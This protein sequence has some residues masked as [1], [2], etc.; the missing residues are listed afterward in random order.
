MRLAASRLGEAMPVTYTE[1]EKLL[2]RLSPLAANP[3]W[4]RLLELLRFDQAAAMKR[5]INASDMRDVAT[6]QSQIKTL[7]GLIALKDQIKQVQAK[8]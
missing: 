6:L 3:D 7:E 1:R 8:Q 2:M 4:D 5:L